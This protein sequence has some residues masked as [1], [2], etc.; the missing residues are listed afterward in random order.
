VTA[1]ANPFEAPI[2]APARR[3]N[4]DTSRRTPLDRRIAASVLD[5][6]PLGLLFV[7]GALYGSVL[8]QADIA[9]AEIR[10][11]EVEAYAFMLALRAG[12]LATIPWSIVQGV[13][14][15]WTGQSFGKRVA[16]ARIVRADGSRVG[17][18]DG[19]LV[20]S[21]AFHLVLFVPIVG[22]LVW[23]ADVA[24]V[25]RGDQRALHDRL[26]GTIVVQT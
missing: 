6:I 4:V 23:L 5:G 26:A 20:R 3:A 13:L 16:G 19:V 17:F 21:W 14:V 8:T 7:I 9:A 11:E 24:L 22:P 15:A 18:V 10:P 12:A 1:P 25:L 2:A